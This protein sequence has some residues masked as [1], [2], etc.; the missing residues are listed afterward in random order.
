MRLPLRP[1]ASATVLLLLDG[2]VRPACP[3]CAPVASEPR[4][5]AV[6]AAVRRAVGYERMRALPAGF[7][8]VETDTAGRDTV[9]WRLGPAGGLPRTP[10][11]APPAAL[12][13]DGGHARPE[14][15]PHPGARPP[16]RRAD[17][18]EGG[19]PP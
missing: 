13:F 4:A 7:E 6:R 19:T 1:A 9:V 5:E 3:A 16:P 2:C 18:A 12:G 17:R 10:A 8:A 14:G 11:T 15:E